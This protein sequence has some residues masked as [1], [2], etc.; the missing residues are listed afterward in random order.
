MS[1]KDPKP[2]IIDWFDRASCREG[3]IYK[4]AVGFETAEKRVQNVREALIKYLIEANGLNYWREVLEQL[5]YDQVD[6][7]GVSDPGH[8][9]NGNVDVHVVAVIFL[10]F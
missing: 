8:W 4:T 3:H 2:I 6:G 1:P 10:E 9:G 7:R 5:L